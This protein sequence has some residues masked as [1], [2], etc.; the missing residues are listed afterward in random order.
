MRN[1]TVEQS[2]MSLSS[3]EVHR[4][5]VFAM[6]VATTPHKIISASFRAS[7]LQITPSLP[8][9]CVM[10]LLAHDSVSNEAM[11][12]EKSTF[13]TNVIATHKGFSL[14]DDVSQFSG[15]FL[16]TT[17]NNLPCIILFSLIPLMESSI[18]NRFLIIFGMVPI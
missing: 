5:V 2:I 3:I 6:I 1:G 4:V 15:P 17:V 12:G 16:Q 8:V 11:I 14:V 13:V 18:L 10:Y 7:D 9:R